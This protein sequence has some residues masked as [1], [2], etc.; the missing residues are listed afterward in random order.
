MSKTEAID[1]GAMFKAMVNKLS[2]LSSDLDAKTSTQDKKIKEL[3]KTVE[4]LVDEN[5]RHRLAVSKLDEKLRYTRERLNT[6]EANL[7]ALA[8]KR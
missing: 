1:A 7:R 6:T 4:R 3:E 8:N 5:K 2:A